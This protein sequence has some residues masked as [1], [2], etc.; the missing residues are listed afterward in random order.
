MI[1]KISEHIYVFDHRN[2]PD[3]LNDFK[4]KEREK[5]QP[6]LIQFERN[7]FRK[8]NWLN[9]KKSFVGLASTGFR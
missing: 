8:E 5:V 2:F 4:I 6:N 3:P 7:R 1:S 9:V